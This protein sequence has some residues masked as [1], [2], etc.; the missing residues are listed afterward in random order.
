MIGVGDKIKA[1]DINSQIIKSRSNI[2]KSKVRTWYGSEGGQLTLDKFVPSINTDHV[3]SYKIFQRKSEDESLSTWS[4]WMG[5]SQVGGAMLSTNNIATAKYVFSQ[6]KVGEFNQ[7]NNWLHFSGVNTDAKFNK[8]MSFA[9]YKGFAPAYIATTSGEIPTQHYDGRILTIT[10]NKLN[11]LKPYIDV[12]TILYPEN[13]IFEE[14]GFSR[15]G[16]MY[17]GLVLRK[18][19]GPEHFDSNY[20]LSSIRDILVEELNLTLPEYT[21]ELNPTINALGKLLGIYYLGD[22][23]TDGTESMLGSVVNNNQGNINIKSL[24]H[25]VAFYDSAIDNI[26]FKDVFCCGPWNSSEFNMM[27]AID[28]VPYNENKGDADVLTLRNFD[29][30]VKDQY[31]VRWDKMTSD[32]M[33]S[34]N[35]VKAPDVEEGE[36]KGDDNRIDIL[37]RTH[38]SWQKNNLGISEPLEGGDEDSKIAKRYPLRYVSLDELMCYIKCHGGGGGE[39][40][41]PGDGLFRPDSS[42]P[43]NWSI[44]WREITNGPGEKENILQLYCFEGK[45]AIQPTLAEMTNKYQ[46]LVRDINHQWGAQQKNMLEY[47]NLSDLLCVKTDYDT[48]VLGMSPMTTSVW[49]ET[50]TRQVGEETESYPAISLY[51]FSDVEYFN[52]ITWENYVEDAN[53]NNPWE[54]LAR[55]DNCLKYVNI[56]NLITPRGDTDDFVPPATYSY[57]Q[58]VD[59]YRKNEIPYISLH[60]FSCP[61]YRFEL[62]RNDLDCLDCRYDFLVRDRCLYGSQS[63]VLKYANIKKLLGSQQ[64]DADLGLNY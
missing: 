53:N 17:L 63:T 16:T 42:V 2:L 61:T 51:R 41:E 56:S 29:N 9:K 59:V 23:T 11:E 1:S 60:K 20:I 55:N 35:G 3:D 10:T 28:I 6:L 49:M 13:F 4:V 37:L 26:Q 7:Y 52:C 5:E 40:P 8:L 44:Q 14:P 27:N 19:D 25:S 48:T 43:D 33:S 46:V 34:M 24:E 31:N 45:S 50:K 64:V 18:S 57:W 62:N 22:I 36:D 54:F 38:L 21:E 39:T 47:A 30:K 32:D 15:D 12:F 58:S